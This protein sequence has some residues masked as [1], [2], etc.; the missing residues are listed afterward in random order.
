[1]LLIYTNV[2]A[3]TMH[4]YDNDDNN[5][6]DDDEELRYPLDEGRAQALPSFIRPH[7]MAENT[8][9]TCTT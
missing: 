9:V 8:F 5:N 7:P 2:T 6:D 4:D 3:C 1:M